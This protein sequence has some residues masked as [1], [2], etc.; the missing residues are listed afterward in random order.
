MGTA[1]T[2]SVKGLFG[3]G[4]DASSSTDSFE[5]LL[6]AQFAALL[7]S[8]V[9]LAQIVERLANAPP[10]S[11]AAP[12][13]AALARALA[14]IAGRTAGE[15]ATTTAGQQNDISGHVLDADTLA[16]EHPAQHENA[17]ATASDSTSLPQ[18]ILAQ[19][20]AA[21]QLLQSP[22]AMASPPQPDPA[23]QTGTA[24]Q[25]Q[26]VQATA[27]SPDLLMRMLTRA[28]QADA[29][30]A[31]TPTGASAPSTP[32]A[33]VSATSQ[34]LPLAPASNAAT[35]ADT[36]LARLTALAVRGPS[37]GE[38]QT[39]SDMF[40]DA[41][42]HAVAKLLA[43]AAKDS[44][45]AGAFG[46][47]SFANALQNAAQ[48]AAAA[49]APAAPAFDAEAVIA[50]IVK[51]VSMHT[52]DG[53]GHVSLRLQPESLGDVSMKISVIGSQI[54]AVV[55]AQNADVRDLLLANAQ[56]LARSFAGAGLKLGSFSV[57]VSGGNPQGDA[58][59][60][61]ADPGESRRIGTVPAAVDSGELTESQH[62]IPIA[63]ARGLMNYFA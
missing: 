42:D 45:S 2:A 22:V 56:Q 27:S 15:A 5:Q 1:R 58:R 3:N 44:G 7:Q 13:A 61:G 63:S 59:R 23:S 39:S 29:Q 60:N 24:A 21:L 36:E 11:T 49:A 26:S 48:N 19:I 34:Q 43:P 30:A 35:I 38:S 40:G 52:S 16:R 54:N 18:E 20:E 12:Q 31:T 25:L 47:P 37:N 41:P 10:G 33:N 50:Q 46:L 57:N 4:K 8:G 55:T 14:T 9:P 28:A 17:T 51:S 6:G 62:G 32:A 53:G